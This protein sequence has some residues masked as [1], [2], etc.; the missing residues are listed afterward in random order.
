ME[1]VKRERRGEERVS[2]FGRRVFFLF[3]FLFLFLY[4]AKDRKKV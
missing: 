1:V 3:P 4:L 2:V